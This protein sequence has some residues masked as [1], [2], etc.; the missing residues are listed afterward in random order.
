MEDADELL[1]I[2]VKLQQ[3]ESFIWIIN[4]RTLS[5]NSSALFD[6]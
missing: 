5:T 2:I 4:E 1:S 3:L 6:G